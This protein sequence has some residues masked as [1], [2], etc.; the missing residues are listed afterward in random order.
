MF[1]SHR[2]I[3]A[4]DHTILREGLKALLSA[5]P[6]LQVVGEAEDGRDAIRLAERVKP[7]MILMDLSMPKMHGTEA[8]REIRKRTPQ[9]KILVLTVHK[10]EEY[11]FAT[12][13]A[14]AAGY[15]VKDA[16][17]AE[18]AAA[19]RA[20]LQGKQYISPSI[21]AGVIRRFVEGAKS[22]HS[23]TSWGALT[24]RERE[25][26]KLIAEGYRNKQIAEMLCISVKTAEKHRAQVMKKLDLHTVPALTA[27]AL[28]R[29]LIGG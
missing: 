5:E 21:S 24:A 29:R 8:I 11:I 28:E 1:T 10:N 25:V 23:G 26:L 16:S 7:D 13:E 14:G 27:Y 2:I 19:I 6:D 9:T 12:F 4:E 22:R 17:Y 18:L 20:V 3:I 15:V